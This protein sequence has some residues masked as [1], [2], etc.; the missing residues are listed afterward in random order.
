MRNGTPWRVDETA[1]YMSIPKDGS[2]PCAAELRDLLDLATL[3]TQR[4]LTE[5]IDEAARARAESS[6]AQAEGL[7]NLDS[8]FGAHDEAKMIAR[9]LLV[10]STRSAE[11]LRASMAK[12]EREA[13]GALAAHAADVASLSARLNARCDA[14]ADALGGELHAAELVGDDSVL[15]LRAEV[16]RREAARIREKGRRD[17]EEERL[18]NEGYET[19]QA[20]EKERADRRV[21]RINHE[22]EIR[23]LRK[24]EARLETEAAEA[25]AAHTAE[26]TRLGEDLASARAEH[27][28]GRDELLTE[29]GELHEA[30]AAQAAELGRE[31]EA[32]AAA[33]AATETALRSDLRETAAAKHAQEARLMDELREEE[34]ARRRDEQ[35]AEARHAKLQL[36]KEESERSLSARIKKLEALQKAALEVGGAGAGRGR[37]LMF[38]EDLKSRTQNPSQT[39]T[40]TV[41]H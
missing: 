28:R 4:R 24:V 7:V 14:V 23:R 15:G 36:E 22:V 11:R 31:L 37:A 33:A 13:D 6:K 34:Q 26:A 25:A 9:T 3:A 19:S 10:Q 39:V 16:A 32:A 30:K 18:R 35:A 20:L 41:S 38:I 17:V 40:Q 21:E 5:A 2:A 27:A 1:R 8:A 12:M 29:L